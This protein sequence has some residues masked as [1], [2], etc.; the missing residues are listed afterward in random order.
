MHM[1]TKYF[2]SGSGKLV[3]LGKTHFDLDKKWLKQPGQRDIIFVKNIKNKCNSQA[4]TD[5]DVVRS[6][7]KWSGL[8]SVHKL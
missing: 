4:I 8:S 2:R 1:I 3:Y 6:F 7:Y 5:L